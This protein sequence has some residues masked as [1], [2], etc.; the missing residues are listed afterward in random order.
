MTPPS[1]RLLSPWL[2]IRVQLGLAAVFIV[3]ALAKIADPPGFAHEISNYKLLPASAVNPLA[4][5][6]PWLELV[7]GICFFLGMFRRTAGRLAA[8]LLV[9]FI[10]ALSI[11]L[12]R[13]RPVD[14]GCFGTSSKP[15]TEAER[16]GD[17]KLAILRDL[18]FLAMTAQL[19]VARRDDRI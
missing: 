5:V 4:L 1:F 17:M 18:F 11:N 14:C 13:G 15:K 10:G 6:L 16:L 19:L 3:A 8:V 12:A 7:I 2:T 9:V